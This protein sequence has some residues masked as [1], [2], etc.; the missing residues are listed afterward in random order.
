MR[1]IVGVLLLVFAC[2]ITMWGQATVPARI[3][4]T[5]GHYYGPEIPLLKANNLT[6][7]QG[8]T[9]LTI[10]SV[11]PLRG[12][13]AGLELFI[14]VD[15]CSSCEVGSNFDELRR[16]IA[17]QPATTSVGVAYIQDGRLEITENLTT[18]R[19]RAIRA[20]TQPYGS[21]ALS[22]YGALADLITNW[23]PRS[24]RRVVLMIST[25]FDPAAAD[26]QS[27]SKSA[28][29]AIQAG[30]RGLVTVYAIYHPSVDYATTAQD[31]LYSGQVLLSHVAEETGG[32]AYYLGFGPL[33]SLAP[34]LADINHHLANQ[35]LV[36]FLA[37][38]GASVGELR[39]VAVK[40]NVPDLDLMAPYRIAVA[41]NGTPSQK[42]KASPVQY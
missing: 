6:I 2:S 3:V 28:E 7:T 29:A 20:L 39:D 14:L 18:D 12:S 19:E 1:K 5:I 42:P 31:K 38:P 24:S 10:T 16:F 37:N 25:G 35:Y 33:T 34:F 11:T 22:P 32:E 30:Q 40:S 17:A 21:R 36:E 41:A 8:V 26:R 15:N 27:E 4:V 23:K 13:H 9:P